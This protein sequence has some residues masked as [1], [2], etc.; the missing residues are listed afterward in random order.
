MAP[1]LN[2]DGQL[3][4][5][6]EK[7]VGRYYQRAAGDTNGRY[8]GKGDEATIRQLEEKAYYSELLKT[9][10]QEEAALEK[11]KAILDK[12]PDYKARM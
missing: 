5:R 10:E 2:V 8:L 9:A 7:G 12:M 6:V 11:I 4:Y 3:S 1:K